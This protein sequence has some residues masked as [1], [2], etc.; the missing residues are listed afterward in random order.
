MPYIQGV[1]QSIV[2]S[3]NLLKPTSTN[4]VISRGA[5]AQ[6]LDKLRFDSRNNDLLAMQQVRPAS[7]SAADPCSWHTQSDTFPKLASP[8]YMLHTSSKRFAG[9]YQTA[10]LLERA[11][12]KYH[13]ALWLLRSST[14]LVQK[15]T[16][17]K[18][19]ESNKKTNDGSCISIQVCQSF[20]VTLKSPWVTKCSLFLLIDRSRFPRN[21][22][23]RR[24][25][26]P[27]L[28]DVPNLKKIALPVGNSLILFKKYLLDIQ[29]RVR[30]LVG[31]WNLKDCLIF[32]NNQ[33]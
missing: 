5:I 18:W 17:A 30:L 11:C 20:Q 21:S 6:V 26:R 16:I 24:P 10:N 12:N 22:H 25:D 9:W 14:N 19:M 32:S 27:P 4:P 28:Q 2:T 23:S 31:H 8:W 33:I 29:H 7:C 13:H 15:C 1:S 3:Q